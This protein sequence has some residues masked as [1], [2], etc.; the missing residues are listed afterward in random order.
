MVQKLRGCFIIK[1]VTFAIQSKLPLRSISFSKGVLWVMVLR[2]TECCGDA[3]S[4]SPEILPSLT[5]TFVIGLAK[6]GVNLVNGTFY[7]PTFCHR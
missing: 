5:K 3:Q 4:C 1:F 6:R 2:F 7:T